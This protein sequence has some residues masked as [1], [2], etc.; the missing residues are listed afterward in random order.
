VH[1]IK[2]GHYALY[3]K[4]RT[5]VRITSDRGSSKTVRE[6]K[7]ALHGAMGTVDYLA[8]EDARP[9]HPPTLR[10]IGIGPTA[11]QDRMRRTSCQWSMSRAAFACRRR[12]GALDG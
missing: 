12:R 8:S 5:P 1:E 3:F 10:G 11:H 9:G 7:V 6:L 4:F 2:A